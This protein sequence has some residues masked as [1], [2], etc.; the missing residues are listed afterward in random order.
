MTTGTALLVD[1]DMAYSSKTGS[2][3]WQSFDRLGA[4]GFWQFH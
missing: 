3:T 2:G 1:T 4:N